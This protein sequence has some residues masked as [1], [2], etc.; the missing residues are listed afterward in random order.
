M[1]G[2]GVDGCDSPLPVTGTGASCTEGLGLW[3]ELLLHSAHARANAS[4][5]AFELLPS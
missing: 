5:W 2:T 1:T 3:H 4:D